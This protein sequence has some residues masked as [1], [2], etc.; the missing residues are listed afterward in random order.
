VRPNHDHPGSYDAGVTPPVTPLSA[1]AL[2][3][4]VSCWADDEVRQRTRRTRRRLLVAAA[5]LFDEA[6]Y[7]GA[8]LS[9]ILTAAGLTKGA[10]YF[11]F[12]SK[13]AL[14]EA[15]VVEVER[16]WDVIV[17]EIAE[18]GLDP[19]WRL[20]VETDAY[21]ARWMH[22]PLVRGVSRAIDDPELR[23]LRSRWL[24]AWER[25]TIER[26]EQAA[27]VSLLAPELDPGRLGRAVVALASGN[28]GL[29]DGPADLWARM[30]ESWAGLLPI[31]AP[32]GW[33][34]AWEASPW[35]TRAAPDPDTYR[36]ARE[37]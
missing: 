27:A 35:L 30:S 9:D 5:A 28:Y 19:L 10:L 14:V 25:A 18:R 4:P 32:P 16:S 22:D 6:G 3:A 31:M 15:L 11:H 8:A 23:A 17:A 12:S 24:T 36:V 21:V 34:A 33:C 26:L 29:A 7:H 37:P 20:L 2:T 1:S 13:Y